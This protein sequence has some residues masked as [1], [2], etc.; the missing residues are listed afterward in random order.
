MSE[1]EI[2]LLVWESTTPCDPYEGHNH[3]LL[4]RTD[5]KYGSCPVPAVIYFMQYLVLN[6]YSW[7]SIISNNPL[8]ERRSRYVFFNS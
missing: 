8:S 7:M 4:S 1:A 5:Q 3:Y 2:E 6:S